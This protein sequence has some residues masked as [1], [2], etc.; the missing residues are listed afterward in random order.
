MNNPDSFHAVAILILK[1]TN[2]NVYI[3]NKDFVKN[4]NHSFL[5]LQ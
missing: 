5:M 3:R 1:E 4:R 2:Q